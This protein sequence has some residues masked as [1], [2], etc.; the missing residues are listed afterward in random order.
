MPAEFAST[1]RTALAIGLLIA[2]SAGVVLGLVLFFVFAVGG[3]L[4]ATVYDTPI[5]VTVACNTGTYYV[6]EQAGS[7]FS[8]PGFSYSHVGT[9]T[10]NPG[11]VQVVSP[12]GGLVPT[13][14]ASG[15]ET[16][17]E[18]SN[19]YS[20]AVGFDVAEAGNY[21]V[22]IRASSLK[23]IVAPSLGSQFLDAAPWLIFTGVGFPL[24]VVG[25]ILLI[26]ESSR[27]RRAWVPPPGAWPVR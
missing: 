6:Y 21:T 10:L 22:T 17:T 2:G 15:N 16:I 3:L 14:A 13:Y 8:V 5:H 12:T 9:T 4:D 26:R 23:V 27:R 24:A 7:G 19:I 11:E 25:L 1:H 18:G 20:N